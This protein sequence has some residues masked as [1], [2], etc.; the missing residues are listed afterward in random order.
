MPSY[1]YEIVDKNGKSKKGTLEADNEQAASQELRNRGLT[2]V[3]VTKAGAL[4]KEISLNFG[5]KVK[6]R[7]LSV[8]CR[9][10]ISM[11]S[12]G[13][14][15][16]DALDMLSEQTENKTMAKALEKVHADIQKGET[17]SDALEKHPKVFPSI[18]ISMVRAGEASG[19]LEIAFERMSEHFE[20]SAKMAG[21]VKKAAMYPIIVSIVAVAVVVLMLVKVIPSY[22]EMFDEMGTGLP[23]LTQ[24]MVNLSK[25]IQAYWYMIIIVVVAVVVAI[26]IFKKT[27]PGQ[28]FFGNLARKMPIFGELT[29]KQAASNFAQTLSTLIY[30]GLPMIEALQITANTMSNYIYKQT[31]QKAKEE[32]AKGVPLSEPI[33][34]SGMFPPMVAHMTYIGEE[35]GDL[36]GMLTRLSMYYEEEVEMTT[37]TVIAAME[38]MIM[39]VLALIVALLVGAIMSPMLK[40]YQNMDNI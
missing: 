33:R 10:F 38:P 7:D 11:V 37:Q 17:L 28:I 32:V 18:M 1:K 30:S 13:V 27:I 29:V 8:F 6:P 22:Q 5:G 25:F 12:A 23:L 24:V 35:T 36:E 15:I 34:D 9:Q 14:T 31:I 4:D 3:S 19:K 20:K 39:L 26:R 40:M 16:M 21:I 2:I